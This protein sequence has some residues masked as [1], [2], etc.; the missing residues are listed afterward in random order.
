VKLPNGN[1]T[2][3]I[4]LWLGTIILSVLLTLLLSSG[5]KAA[6]SQQVKDHMD[7]V[8]LHETEQEKTRRIDRIVDHRVAVIEARLERIERDLKE[9]KH[10][11]Q[12]KG[13]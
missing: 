3:K 8:S 6:F 7:S 10:L 12:E 1:E 9:I 11:L 2:L 13:D 4:A 5:G